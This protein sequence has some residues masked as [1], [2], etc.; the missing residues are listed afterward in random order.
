MKLALLGTGMIVKEVL[1]I[2]VAI[3]G[4]ELKAILSTKRSLPQAQEL[5]E[6]YDIAMATSD[7]EAILTNPDIDTVYVG[8]PNHTHYHYAKEALL[9]GKHVICE[10]PFTL[11]LAEFEELATLAKKQDLLLMEAI[12]NQYL[13]NF[14]YIKES[15]GKIGDVKIVNVNYSQYSSRY[16]AFK[17]G[18]IA[19]AFNPEMGGGALRDLN[20][21]NIHLLVGLFGRPESVDYLPN[22]ENGVDT[23]GILVLDYGS[24][25]A[26]AI[27]AKDCNAEIRS[28]IQGNQGSITILGGTN[29]LPQV[30][31]SLNGQEPLEPQVNS[32][33]HR[34][35]DEFLAFEAMVASKDL[36]RA[37]EGLEH[38]RLVMAVLE[39]A[40]QALLD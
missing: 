2:L 27:G 11:H 37:E 21:Y 3:D 17:R 20:I 1:P 23:S 38:S 22:M 26:V 30:T 25:K 7:L 19:P 39:E 33:Q 16:D 8:T 35:Y 18:Q 9:A 10:K 13:E 4:I 6:Q 5:A 29:E 12:T 15:L 28:T 31:L 14:T 36:R 40:S 32:A 34:M 24:F